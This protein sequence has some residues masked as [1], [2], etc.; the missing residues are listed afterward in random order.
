MDQRIYVT[1]APNDSPK[2]FHIVQKIHHQP[3]SKR[4]GLRDFI[5]D[6]VHEMTK[7]AKK[8]DDGVP[9]EDESIAS[10][11]VAPAQ[12]PCKQ[13]LMTDLADSL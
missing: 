11:E 7:P 8:D 13:L 1:F 6:C 3:K 9:T 2:Q 10:T 4:Y 12:P 5:P